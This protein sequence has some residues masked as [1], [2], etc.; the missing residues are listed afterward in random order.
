M[1]HIL[2]LLVL[3]FIVWRSLSKS[4]GRGKVV[5]SDAG[6][7]ASPLP[8]STDP[9]RDE[10]ADVAEVV[11]AFFGQKGQ[12]RLGQAVDRAIQ[13]SKARTEIGRRPAGAIKPVER[14]QKKAAS[15]APARQRAR[16]LLDGDGGHRQ[17]TDRTARLQQS[18]RGKGLCSP[19]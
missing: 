6:R 17:R 15:Q 13:E 5:R 11:S 1:S 8:A 2:F 10:I 16:Y 19:R 14:P 4:L 7:P 9:Q 3:A 12:E 18:F